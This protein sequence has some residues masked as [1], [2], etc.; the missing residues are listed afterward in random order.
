MSLPQ[1]EITLGPDDYL[2]WEQDQPCRN[3]YVDGKVFAKGGASDAH[4]KLSNKDIVYESTYTNLFQ[5]R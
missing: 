1:P 2:A 5:L 3:E 4:G